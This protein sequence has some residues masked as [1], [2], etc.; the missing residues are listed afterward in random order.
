MGIINR[1]A[2]ENFLLGFLLMGA[3]EG[4]M[5]DHKNALPTDTISKSSGKTAER[6]VITFDANAVTGYLSSEPKNCGF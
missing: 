4:A 1:I 6:P 3:G 5:S 2:L